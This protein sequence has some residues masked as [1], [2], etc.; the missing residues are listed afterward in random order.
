V[1]TVL[2][3]VLA[4]ACNALSSVLQRRGARSIPE[5]KSMRLALAVALLQ[6]PVWLLGLLAMVFAFVFQASA[7]RHGELALVQPIML[8]ELPL[9]LLL[10]WILFKASAERRAWLGVI[11]MCGGLA[12]VLAAAAPSGGRG[13]VGTWPIILMAL[14]CAGLSAALV[15][16]AL[17]LEGPL[18]AATFGTA[19]GS[20]F[21]LTAA[22]MK[23]AM[24]QFDA[25]SVGGLV[26]TWEFYAMIVA[27]ATSLFLWQNALQAATLV[28]AQPAITLSDPVLAMFMGVLVFG[29]RVRLGG[30]LAL[31][32]LGALV[33]ALA[34]IELA[35]SPLVAGPKAA[36]SPQQQNPAAQPD[37]L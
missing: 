23:Q 25:D 18:R 3:A 8:A 31:E 29:E 21:A 14:S 37:P 33:I 27:G 5:S 9:T 32:F 24:H 7:L 19:A 1:L 22:L 13:A 17:R 6:R 12:A 10:G 15:L 30:W 20:G 28:A 16:V 26:T 4:A 35:R 34:S 2:F 11:G 36:R